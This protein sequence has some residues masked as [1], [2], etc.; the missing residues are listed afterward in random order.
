MIYPSRHVPWQSLLSQSYSLDLCIVR[1][2]D[3]SFHIDTVAHAFTVIAPPFPG[4]PGCFPKTNSNIVVYNFV[5]VMAFETSK[6]SLHLLACF[7]FKPTFHQ[8]P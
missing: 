3:L 8:L 1:T 7:D 5:I 2:S 4:Y 6:S